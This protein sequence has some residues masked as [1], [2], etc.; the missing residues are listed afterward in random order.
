MQKQ[1]SASV[2]AVDVMGGD[3]GPHEIIEG[4]VLALLNQNIL[5]HLLLVGDQDIIYPVLKTRNIDNDAR[6]SVLHTTEVIG[7]AEKPIQSLKQKKDASM[8]RALEQIKDNKVQA[9]LSCGNTGSL[10]AGGVL[11]L[12]LMNGLERPALA[13]VIPSYNNR[14]IL[15]DAGANPQAEPIHLVQNAILGSHYAQ[16]VLKKEKPRVCLLTIGTGEGKGTQCV[17]ETHTHLKKLDGII[18]YAGLIEGFGVFDGNVDVVVCDGF[19]GNIVLKSCESL[20]V[21][22]KRFIKDEIMKNTLRKFGALLCQ[23]AFKTMKNELSPERYGGAPL[24]GV[25]GTVMK[26]HGSSNKMAIMHAIRIT[27]EILKHD[28]NF[29][30]QDAITKANIVLNGQNETAST[31]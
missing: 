26:A 27:E 6:I 5:S 20:F 30:M 12:R 1:S 16:V 19:V 10:M 28:L 4:A 15:I 18:N 17:N 7:M 23:G 25:K 21:N 24:L 14:F 11:K 22:M 3:R 29:H 8:V 2:I 9:V 13:S 31:C